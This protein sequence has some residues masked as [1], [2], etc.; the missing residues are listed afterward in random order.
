M[1]R[2]RLAF[3][4]TGPGIAPEHLPRLFAPFERVHADRDNIE[5]TGIGL[6]ICKRL[7]E[8]M[9]GTLSVESVVGKGCTFTVELPTTSV[10]VDGNLSDFAFPRAPDGAAAD[11]LAPARTQTVLHIEDN[12]ANLE[13][14]E[15]LF[16]ERPGLRLL[17]AM[18]GRLGLDLAREHLP[19]LSGE[20]VLARLRANGLTQETPVVVLSADALPRRVEVLRGLG[21]VDYLTKP[22]NV[23]RFFDVL[24]TRLARPRSP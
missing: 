11:A 15:R 17:N 14:V 18:Q 7:A 9:G 21:A 10:A 20:E 4:D 6:S 22:L 2:A 1:G 23:P 5:G 3:H 16:L 8:A 13:L 12:P 19:D 24:D